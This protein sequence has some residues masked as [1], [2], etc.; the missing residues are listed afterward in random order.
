MAALD[1]N[2]T[3]PLT[4]APA[5]GMVGQ[6]QIYSS[7][8]VTMQVPPPP[9]LPST[10]PSNQ[11]QMVTAP[12]GGSRFPKALLIILGVVVVLG[13]IAFAAIKFLLPQVSKSAP[14][15]LTWWGLWEDE[16]TVS[17]LI[18]DYES[19]HPNV[20]ITYVKQSKEDYRERLTNTLAKGTDGPDIFTFHNTWAPMYKNDLDVIPPTVMA[21]QEYSQTFFPVVSSDLR[22]QN[23]LVGIPLGI[24]TIALFINT[25][26]FATY[27]KTAPRTWDDLRQTALDLTIKDQNGN[28][29][30]SGVALGRTENVDNWQEVLALMMVQNG[31]NLT[32]MTPTDRAQ[33]ALS[34]FTVFSN[35]DHVWDETLP[36]STVAFATGKTAMYFGPS[37]RVFDIKQQ[38]PNLHFS[39][40]PVPQLPKDN[41]SQPDAAYATYWAQG[42][43]AKSP[44]K[45]V[46]WDFLKFLSSKDSLQKLYQNAASVRQFGEPYPRQDM[47][48]LLSSDQ[49]MGAF[50]SQAQNAQSWFLASRTFD[51]ATGINSQV[52]KYFEDAVNSINKG[53][54]VDQV[55]PTLTS[56]VTQVLSNYGLTT[57]PQP[58]QP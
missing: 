26:I 6:G 32:S 43:W 23:G 38:N 58:S 15:T 7:E 21:S 13:G 57:A 45:T 24:D 36:P 47:A 8:G 56:G 16:A 33:T 49:T 20:K 4:P 1:P 35:T 40:V 53:T 10:P 28:I 54:G 34:F 9:A 25:D 3:T 2:S 52:S 31:V 44:S 42:V 14:V 27:G 11:Q 48:S 5:A 17:P 30:Q 12:S 22:T 41:P 19:Q 37:W 50:E 55:L 29:T 39:V 46:A 18:S 51:G